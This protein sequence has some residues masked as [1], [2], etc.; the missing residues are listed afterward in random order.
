MT[1]TT[2]VESNAKRNRPYLGNGPE[3]LAIEGYRNMLAGIVKGKTEFWDIVWDAHIRS[4]GETAGTHA[5]EALSDFVIQFGICAGCPLHH[6][7]PGSIHICRDEC[8]VLA[9]IAAAQHGEED[10]LQISAQ[11][12]SSRVQPSGIIM[13]ISQYALILKGSGKLFLPIPAFELTNFN[14]KLQYSDFQSVSIH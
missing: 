2:I 1:V 14:S 5:A 8:F 7:A 11:L 6:F 12:L 9:M 3:A 13:A 4:L 10:V